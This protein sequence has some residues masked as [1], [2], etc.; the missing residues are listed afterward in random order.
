MYFVYSFR[1]LVTVTCRCYYSVILGWCFYFLYHSIF[2]SLPST[3]AESLDNWQSLQDT[4]WPIFVHFL[5]LLFS[6]LAVAK[7]VSSI[8]LVNKIVV[9]LLL[10]ILTFSFCWSL[11]LEYASY[12]ISFL[13]TPDW[14]MIMTWFCSVSQ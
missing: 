12:G 2:F 14:G 6:G 8:E 9:P 1:Y 4:K 10:I 13:F 7:A 11:S 3:K 5:S